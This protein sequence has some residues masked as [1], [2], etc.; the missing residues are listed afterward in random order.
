MSVADF[1]RACREYAERF[2]GVMT[3]EFQR[4]G[5]LGDW[6]HP[7]LT[8]DFKY[9][10]AIVRALGQVRRAGPRLQ[11]QEAGP[12][13][14]PLPHGARRSG[15]RVRG[16]HLAVDLR[17][18]PAV[19]GQRATSSPRASRRSPDA[20][21]RSSSG[22]R[23]RGRSRRTWRSRSIRTSTTRRTRSDGRAVIV[24]EALAPKVAEVGGGPF[25][26]PVAR[27]KGE[28]TR[29]HPLPASALR[30]RSRSACWP[31]TSRSTR[32]RAPCTRR[33]ATA[34]TTSRPA[35]RYGLDIYAPVGPGGHFLDTVE[36]VRRPAGVRGEPGVEAA[37]EERGRL[38]HRETFTHPYPHCWRCHN[39]VIFLATSQWFIRMDGEPVVGPEHARRCAQA[40]LDAIDK[41]VTWIPAWGRDRMYDMLSNRPDWCISRQRAWGVP[42]PAV[43]CTTCGEA[44][45]TPA[46]VERAAAVFDE[47]GAD[48]WYE[49]P[50]EEFLP[51]GLR[52][53]VVRRH[54][55][56]ARARH[57]RRVVRLG[58]EPRG[59]AA[60]PPGADLA[61]RHLPRGQR[62]VSRL[63]PELAARR[64]RHARTAAVPRGADARLRRRRRRPQD[65]EVARQRRSRRRTSSRRAARRSSACGSRWSTTATRCASASR[66]SRASSRRTGRSAT[67]C[68][69]WSSNLY[70]FDPAADRVAA[71]ARC[72][73]S[74]ASRSRATA[75]PRRAVLRGVRALRLPD[76][77]PDDERV[78]DRRPERVLRRRVEGSALHVAA[79]IARAAVGA[80]GDVRHRRRPGAAARADPVGDGRRSVAAPARARARTSVHLA[81]V[82]GAPTSERLRRRRRSKR[83]GTRLR[84]H[85]RRG[86]RA[87]SRP[88]ARRR[89]SAPRSAAHVTLDGR[90]RRPRRCSRRYDADLPMLFIVVA[91]HARRDRARDGVSVDGERAADGEK[92]PRCWRFVARHLARARQPRACAAAA[93]TRCGGADGREV[94]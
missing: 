86:Q 25:G 29:A 75:R 36:H 22:R 81:D 63:V 67:R 69:T 53:P 15:S 91:G 26:A 17:R 72:W 82:P 80:D 6:D 55:V 40:G 4:L 60:V 56:R 41:D 73:R 19:A 57:P 70:D 48:A 18:V 30:A 39:P 51:A 42:I 65:V 90:R 31:T 3:E 2:I 58:V 24:A 21:S 49:R 66:S 9:Q 43:D 23:R 62:P 10:A 59:G 87:R 27:F 12:L 20:T 47:Y 84:E 32:A 68:A 88:R 33:P 44:M 93:S 5:I 54:R 78:R 34:R 83:A 7:Y 77:L 35:S 94:A 28:L 50:I 46:L 89:R 8:M 11:R 14:H 92:C 1:R 61:G 13:V 52:V 64:P 71:R 16:P 37:L 79:R 76:D 85:P 38:W 45:L 74:I